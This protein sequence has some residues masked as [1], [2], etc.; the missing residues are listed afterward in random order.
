MS[1]T[2]SGDWGFQCHRSD[3]IMWLASSEVL[4][5]TGVG[6]AGIELRWRM[7]DA[8]G[9]SDDVFLADLPPAA[10][11]RFDVFP[12]DDNIVLVPMPCRLDELTARVVAE[13]QKVVPALLRANPNVERIGVQAAPVFRLQVWEIDR[14]L[15]VL[16]G[17]L[18]DDG[19]TRCTRESLVADGKARGKGARHYP[20]TPLVEELGGPLE[21]RYEF[22]LLVVTWLLWHLEETH[23]PLD[24]CQIEDDSDLYEI[25]E[26]PIEVEHL[27]LEASVAKCRKYIAM[28]D[29]AAD[30]TEASDVAELHAL[31][32]GV[33]DWTTPLSSTHPLAARALR[34]SAGLWGVLG[35]RERAIREMTWGVLLNPSAENFNWRGYH[36][37]LSG[38]LRGAIAD[39]TKALGHEKHHVYFSN[40]AEAHL[41]LGDAKAARRDA[42]ASLA[43]NARNPTARQWLE[44]STAMLAAAKP[45]AKSTLQPAAAPGRRGPAPRGSA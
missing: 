25:G 34:V 43:L 5:G 6:E 17:Q 26:D 16:R 24:Y 27:R 20:E 33:L 30:A 10:R 36:R 23:G 13:M 22:L 11:R 9:D 39:Y 44:K 7:Y 4:D 42:M 21:E 18:P 2:C 8:A 35:R 40:R 32:I 19:K 1:H 28:L 45:R 38:D 14:A 31:R 3:A 12:V 15:E 37:H 41:E 29:A